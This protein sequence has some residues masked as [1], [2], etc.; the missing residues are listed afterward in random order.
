VLPRD[1]SF[2]CGIAE[3][4]RD[5]GECAAF[6]GDKHLNLAVV[7]A[8]YAQQISAGGDA[9][10]MSVGEMSVLTAAATSNR[11]LA[12]LLSRLLTPELVAA[13]PANALAQGLSHSV[14]TMVEAAVFL[15]HEGS[16]EGPEA[17]AEV[18]AF[19]LAEAR[20]AHVG[21]TSNYK[22]TLLELLHLGIAG[23]LRT[24]P[25]PE[26]GPERERLTSSV[27]G[28]SFVSVATLDGATAVQS[29][30]NKREA[31]QKAARAVFQKL[32][33][34]DGGNSGGSIGGDTHLKNNKGWTGTAESP[35]PPHR[36]LP[37]GAG[38][39][40]ASPDPNSNV[41]AS[42][43]SGS[44]LVVNY[45]GILLEFVAKG[46]DG[47]LTVN[48]CKFQMAR[49]YFEA[50][51][52]LDGAK[53]VQSGRS[54]REAEQKAARAV[55]ERLLLRDASDGSKARNRRVAGKSKGGGSASADGNGWT[56]TADHP[57]APPTSLR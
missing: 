24:E 55:F 11:L 29:G 21:G 26:P 43:A 7:R 44:D 50:T 2:G 31:E 10:T 15:V 8:L 32:L 12:R 46:V 48:A 6:Y 41:E 16:D 45:K 14:G 33:L 1:L 19:L 35:K 36:V 38:T 52:C 51:A 5:L 28:V 53:A 54:K 13:V 20:G 23:G 57:V 17:V 4:H 37:A 25:G 49:P 40:A 9:S 27:R 22:G 56:G 47:A 39:S 34:R 30:R 18:G 3:G 42:S